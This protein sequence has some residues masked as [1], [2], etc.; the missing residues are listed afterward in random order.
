SGTPAAGTNTFTVTAPVGQA[1]T[2]SNIV[3]GTGNGISLISGQGGAST[4][5]AVNSNGGIITFQTGAP[6]TGGSGTAGQYGKMG[7]D[8]LGGN[9]QIGVTSQANF[10]E[11]EVGCYGSGCNSKGTRMF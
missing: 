6:G 3:G 10:G 1:G 5:N 11:L 9:V 8:R 2:G 4:G 7:I